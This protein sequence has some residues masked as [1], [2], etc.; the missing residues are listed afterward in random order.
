MLGW[1]LAGERLRESKESLAAATISTSNLIWGHPR[2][3]TRPRGEK[4]TC[5]RLGYKAS[6][7]SL[8]FLLLPLWSIGHPWKALFH[9]SFLILRQS[10][11]IPGRR[12]SPSQGRYLY[13]HRISTD[14][15][16]CPEWDSNPQAQPYRERRE[17]M[18]HT[19]QPLWPA[20]NSLVTPKNEAQHTTCRPV[21]NYQTV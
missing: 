5:C 11:R 8:S 16:P 4:P 6:S 14:K 13:K 10:V 12:I 7:L 3:N 20:A 2:P 19:A 15:H 9:F 18:P 1:R 21:M 17:F